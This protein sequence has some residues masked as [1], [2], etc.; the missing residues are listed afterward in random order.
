MTMDPVEKDLESRRKAIAKELELLFKANMKITD[1]N[2]PEANDRK[3][4]ELLL[5]IM[6]EELEKIGQ[7]IAAGKYDNY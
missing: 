5:K 3:A 6:Q 7:D 2:V 1:W 4:A